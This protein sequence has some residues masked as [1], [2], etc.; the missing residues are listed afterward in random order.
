ML[1]RR[2]GPLD[3][4]DTMYLDIAGGAIASLRPDL[5]S[6]AAVVLHAT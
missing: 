5:P 3:D 1:T 2:L 4:I 6:D